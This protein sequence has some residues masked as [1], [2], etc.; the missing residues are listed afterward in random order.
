MRDP[1][2]GRF[3]LRGFR[4][5]GG[6]G[7]Y[8]GGGGVGGGSGAGG[9]G[10]G[11]ATGGAGG[12]GAGSGAGGAGG[13]GAGGAG[14]SGGG[15]SIYNQAAWL[16]QP[17]D[18]LNIDKYG[19]VALPAIGATAAIVWDGSQFKIPSGRM[20][21]FTGIG[22]DFQPN[23]TTTADQIFQQDVLP[24]Q[25]E[26]SLKTDAIGTSFGDFAL[27]HYLP[28]SVSDPMGIAGLMVRENQTIT[29]TVKNIS[30]VVA[31]PVQFIGAHIQ[32][33]SYSSKRQPKDLGY[34]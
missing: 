5:V 24:Y 10:A 15:A 19:S 22:M 34:Q 11:G 30:V 1:L 9:T 32:G 27:F 13:S 6:G 29:L 17:S 3:L 16:L 18:F 28:G 33:Y 25:L 20:A 8:S 23:G 4:P 2:L 14:G 26:F 7:G 12:A 21:K 31:A